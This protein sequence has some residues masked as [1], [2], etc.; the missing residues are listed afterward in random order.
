MEILQTFLV[1]FSIVLALRYLY[2]KYFAAQTDKGCGP[3]CGC[4]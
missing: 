2:K 4:H 1:L 3:D